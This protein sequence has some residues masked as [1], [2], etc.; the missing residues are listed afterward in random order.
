M[1]QEATPPATDAEREA[2]Y[3]EV[4]GRRVDNIL[5]KLALTDTNKAGR[6]RTALLLQYRTLRLRDEAMDAHLSA[7][8]KNPTDLAG[9]ADLR[10]EL[11]T[12][13]RQWFVSA[14]ALDLNPGQIETIK[15]EM[16][17]GK[18]K[19]TFDAYCQIVPNLTETDKAK[20]LEL[21][22]AARDEAIDGGSAPEKSAIFQAHKDQINSYLDAHGHDV[23]KAYKDWESK[24]AAKPQ[25]AARN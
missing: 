6:V 25:D 3:T 10:R 4:L 9:R 24:M 7:Q 16:T 18:V 11:S 19:V 2:L 15:D 20:I 5:Q 22:K 21:L 12:P 8:G 1:A 14:L 17:Y 23:A 13:L